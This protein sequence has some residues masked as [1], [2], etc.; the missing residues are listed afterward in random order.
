MIGNFGKKKTNEYFGAG[1]YY[2][3]EYQRDYTW[4]DKTEVSI[5]KKGILIETENIDMG[6]RNIDRDICYIY[7]INRSRAV[8][9]KEK[10]ALCHK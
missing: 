2:I 1:P 10:F 6:S 8:E 3:P 9:L 5:F 7:D 4:E